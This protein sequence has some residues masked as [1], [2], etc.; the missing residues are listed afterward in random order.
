MFRRLRSI[1][2]RYRITT[3]TAV[4][5]WLL[6]SFVILFGLAQ[7]NLQG[8]NKPFGTDAQAA[9]NSLINVS[10][11]AKVESVKKISKLTT[12]SNHP[13]IFGL[14]MPLGFVFVVW[15]IAML[16]QHHTL[17]NLFGKGPIIIN[18]GALVQVKVHWWTKLFHRPRKQ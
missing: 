10:T 7:A 11:H 17:N 2:F 5:V 14:L 1:N 4:N 8:N 6:L 15:V 3:L 16:W 18:N 13:I 12:G 9:S